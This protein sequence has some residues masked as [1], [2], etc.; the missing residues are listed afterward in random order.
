M[1]QKNRKS[2]GRNKFR[3]RFDRLLIAVENE[4]SSFSPT[5]TTSLATLPVVEMDHSSNVFI[6]RSTFNSAQ[7]DFHVHTRDSESG[8]HNFRS[9]HTSILI[10]DTMKDFVS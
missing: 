2:R 3:I 9:V 6:H 10:N 1:R 5:T 7:G 8:M 4:E